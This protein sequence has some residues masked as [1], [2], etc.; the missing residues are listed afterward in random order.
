MAEV[1]CTENSQTF[2]KSAKMFTSLQIFGRQVTFIATD[3]DRY[4]RTIAKIYYDNKYLSEE[5]IKAGF[6]WWYYKYSDDKHL[7]LLQDQAQ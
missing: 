4:G 2:G 6:G 5:I 7:G 1:D 3:V